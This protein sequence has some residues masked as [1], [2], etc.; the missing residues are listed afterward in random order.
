MIGRE[1]ALKLAKPIAKI[2]N[3]VEK[4]L[5]MR[6]YRHIRQ[7]PRFFNIGLYFDST[8]QIWGYFVNSCPVV[9]ISIYIR[10]SK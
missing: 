10:K 9:K 2:N 4:A 5:G 6:L 8:S 7:E 3:N 1:S